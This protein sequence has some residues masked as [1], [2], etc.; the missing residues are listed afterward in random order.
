M[1]IVDNY[2]FEIAQK[3]AKQA[4]ETKNQYLWI[5]AMITLSRSY[6]N[7]SKNRKS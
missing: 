7:D 6:S 2:A 3:Y 1:K 4:L 5:Q